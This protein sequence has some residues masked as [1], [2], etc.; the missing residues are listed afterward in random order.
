MAG[1]PIKT[2]EQR[3]REAMKVKKRMRKRMNKS[4]K[5]SLFHRY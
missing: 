5:C 4:S 2:N 3:K 1:K